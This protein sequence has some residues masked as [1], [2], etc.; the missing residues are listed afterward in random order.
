MQCDVAF[1]SSCSSAATRCRHFIGH[2]IP[3]RCSRLA[4]ASALA[5]GLLLAGC[6]GLQTAVGDDEGTDTSAS[7]DS[8]SELEDRPPKSDSVDRQSTADPEGGDETPLQNVR[9]VPSGRV[10]VNDRGWSATDRIDNHTA[11][12]GSGAPVTFMSVRRFYWEDAYADRIELTSD[13]LFGF[14]EASLSPSAA[15]IF[16]YL[17]NLY[18]EELRNQYVYVV[19]HTDSRGAASYNIGLSARRAASV[20]SLFS[21]HN[22]PTDKLNVIPAGEHMPIVAND[23]ADNRALNRRVEIYISPERDLPTQLI[24]DTTCPIDDCSYAELSML[25]VD[26]SYRLVQRSRNSGLPSTIIPMESDVRERRLDASQTTREPLTMPVDVRSASVSPVIRE[27]RTL[28]GEYLI[29][30]E[31]ERWNRL[32]TTPR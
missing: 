32:L 27:V 18:D 13:F 15:S 3:L 8:A 28:T 21:N 6:G 25:G 12:D 16:E 31:H 26:R 19:G 17:T 11:D 23:T 30:E 29:Q 22:L 5:I 24:R 10:L 4:S 2:T 14:D 9:T 7:L 20:V 1:S